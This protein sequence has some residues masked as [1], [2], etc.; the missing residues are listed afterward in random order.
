MDKEDVVHIYSGTVLS[1]KKKQNWVICS[2]VDGPEFV[3][4]S[5]VRKKN[6][7]LYTESRKMVQMRLF[8]RIAIETQ[9]Q[10]K[11]A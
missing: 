8:L 10:G 7:Y 5:E 11:G 6:K 1:Q 4:Q 2:D 9:M 3:I